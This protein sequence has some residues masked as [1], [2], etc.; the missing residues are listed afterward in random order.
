MR[1]RRLKTACSSLTLLP[2][3]TWPAWNA[4]QA[5][6]VLWNQLGPQWTPATPL[7]FYISNISAA[8]V[9]SSFWSAGEFP[10][11]LMLL[12]AAFFGGVTMAARGCEVRA[13]T[14]QVLAPRSL[15]RALSTRPHR[16]SRARATHNKGI[17]LDSSWN[18][19]LLARASLPS[20]RLNPSRRHRRH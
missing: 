16:S 6:Q 12:F 11:L 19:Q 2:P 13:H 7:S 17:R 4:G 9:Q 20:L 8:F 15:S 1:R 3:P 14:G 5:E 18:N 10:L